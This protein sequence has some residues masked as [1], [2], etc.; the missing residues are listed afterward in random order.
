M[1]GAYEKVEV[2]RLTSTMWEVILLFRRLVVHCKII[3]YF[4]FLHV[5]VENFI[6]TGSMCNTWC[7]CIL[8][9]GT[10]DLLLIVTLYFRVEK[11]II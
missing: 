9:I 6:Q 3:S 5:P 1:R 4:L 10:E 2:D 11:Q 7:S 8:F